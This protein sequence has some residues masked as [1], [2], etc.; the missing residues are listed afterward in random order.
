MLQLGGVC[1]CVGGGGGGGGWGVPK[2]SADNVTLPPAK[3]SR[4]CRREGHNIQINVNTH[5]HT[6]LHPSILCIFS[7][8]PQLTHKHTMWICAE[9]WSHH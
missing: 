7:P 5:V 9:V 1:V 2:V 8:K 4:T 6:Y 3:K